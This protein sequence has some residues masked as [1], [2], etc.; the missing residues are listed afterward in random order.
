MYDDCKGIERAGAGIESKRDNVKDSEAVSTSVPDRSSGA[1]PKKKSSKKLK[2]GSTSKRL[3]RLRRKSEIDFIPSPAEEYAREEPL[4]KPSSLTRRHVSSGNIRERRKRTEGL[5]KSTSEVGQERAGSANLRVEDIVKKPIPRKRSSG[6]LK[7]KEKSSDSTS[8]RKRSGSARSMCQAR[9]I[10]VTDGEEKDTE[11]NIGVLSMRQARTIG[12]V[13]GEEK[14]IGA[15]SMRQQRTTGAGKASSVSKKKDSTVSMRKS[16][17]TGRS[18]REARTV[19]VL[20]NGELPPRNSGMQDAS[21]TPPSLIIMQDNSEAST[22]SK[23]V[24]RKKSSSTTDGKKKKSKSRTT[25]SKMA[26]MSTPSSGEAA[27]SMASTST[28]E[29]A[30]ESVASDFDYLALRGPAML[31]V[32]ADALDDTCHGGD[33]LVHF[34]A[35]KPQDLSKKRRKEGLEV[36]FG[37][38]PRVTVH[39]VKDKRDVSTKWYLKSDLDQLMEHE[40]RINMLQAGGKKM[41]QYCC[42][43]G[44]ESQLLEKKMALRSGNSSCPFQTKQERQAAHVRWVL[45][46]QEALRNYVPAPKKSQSSTSGASS[47]SKTETSGSEEENRAE[48]LRR[49]CRSKTKEDRNVAYKYGQ[50][51]ARESQQIHKQDA[52]YD[53]VEALLAANE[54]A[55]SV[56]PIFG[57]VSSSVRGSTDSE[58]GSAVSGRS[59]RESIRSIMPGSMSAANIANPIVGGD[60]QKQNASMLSRFSIRINPTN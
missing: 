4:P 9:T 29:T 31:T 51:D 55:E 35:H 43:R 18:T 53:R 50:Q 24:I 49:K 37:D 11:K 48:I 33:D 23:K 39:I 15:R 7:K 58:R 45:N 46:L 34:P 36:W 17:T 26:Q 40:L 22:T 59:V 54:E 41:G 16:R 21:D 42:Q 30:L 1:S 28:M 56:F 27:A 19:D 6:S 20:L 60:S 47:E 57:S 12:V 8:D 38:K 14:N 32:E 44:V 5:S 10:G 13:D 2:K 3:E 52:E 25:E